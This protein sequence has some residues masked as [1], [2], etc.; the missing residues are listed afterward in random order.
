M[1]TTTRN[2]DANPSE[3]AIL[4]RVLGNEDG[5]S[6]PVMARYVLTLGFNDHEKARMHD[7]VVRNQEG[8]LSL[9]EQDEL[10]AYAKGA[11]YSPSSNSRLDAHSASNPKNAPPPNSRDVHG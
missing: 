10:F 5:E 6:P 3:V 1:P 2:H 11:P 4:A 9:A 7:L 8:A